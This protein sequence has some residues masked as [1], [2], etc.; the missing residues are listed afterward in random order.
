MKYKKEN[1]QRTIVAKIEYGG[2]TISLLKHHA[3][4]WAIAKAENGI[5]TI[6]MMPRAKARAEFKKLKKAYSLT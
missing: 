4:D 3:F 2:M 6:H 1:C 5:I